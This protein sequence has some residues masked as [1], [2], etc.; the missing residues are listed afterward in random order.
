MGNSFTKNN[1][2]KTSNLKLSLLKN[3]QLVNLG[4][5]K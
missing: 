3:Y 1:D 5:G 4:E 2:F